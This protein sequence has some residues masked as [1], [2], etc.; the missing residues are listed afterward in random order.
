MMIAP[1][2]RRPFPVLPPAVGTADA[3]ADRATHALLDGNGDG[4]VTRDEFKRAGW[5]QD[6]FKLFDAD[7][8]GKVSE[9][10]FTQARRFEREF[11]AKDGNDDGFLSRP[12][13]EGIRR[14][15]GDIRPTFEGAK[16]MVMRCMPPLIRDR[17]A[18][19]DKDGDGK[20]SKEEFFAAR[21]K[22]E[23]PIRLTPQPWLAHL[24]KIKPTAN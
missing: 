18:S 2:D 22:D 14:F 9:R 11:N 3:A 24:D 21:R 23:F 8:D 20:V 15:I 16:D 17:F 1:I 5:S 7:G 12:E 6:R 4:N 13:F 10:E 19:A